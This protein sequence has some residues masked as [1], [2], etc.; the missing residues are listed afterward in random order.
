MK[1]PSSK[2]RRNPP[3]IEVGGGAGDFD[4]VVVHHG[5]PAEDHAEDPVAQVV[6]ELGEDYPER[7]AERRGNYEGRADP[8]DRLGRRWGR[9][10]RFSGHE[11]IILR[12]ACLPDIKIG[13]RDGPLKP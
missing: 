12:L 11:K 4:A 9:H 7:G 13:S 6:Q 2:Q 8:L 5:A 10:C 3:A 1:N